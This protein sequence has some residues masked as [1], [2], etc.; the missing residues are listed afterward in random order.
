MNQEELLTIYLE[1]LKELAL[2]RLHERDTTAIAALREA[3]N[4]I[5]GEM[6]GY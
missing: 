3:F 1:R 2:E 4:I 6:K 5:E